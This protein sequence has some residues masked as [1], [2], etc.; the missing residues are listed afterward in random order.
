MNNREAYDKN[1]IFDLLM[2][3]SREKYLLMRIK[4]SHPLIDWDVLWGTVDKL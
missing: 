4:T 2:C 1:L 3:L